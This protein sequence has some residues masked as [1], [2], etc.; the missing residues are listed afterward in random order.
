MKK[1]IVLQGEVYICQ[2][3]GIENEQIGIRPCVIIQ[4]DIL[5]KTSPNVIVVPIT[6]RQKK[7]LPTHLLFKKEKY[8]FLKYEENTVLCES[9]RSISKKRLGKYIG[10]IADEDLGELLKRKEYAYIKKEY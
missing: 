3:D 9:I 1:R 5:N 7:D 8:P 10:R 4:L 2:L 6:S